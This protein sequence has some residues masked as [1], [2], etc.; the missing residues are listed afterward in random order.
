MKNKISTMKCLKY[1]VN[2]KV[3]FMKI[4]DPKIV[5]FKCWSFC[6]INIDYQKKVFVSAHWDTI[7]MK[8]IIQKF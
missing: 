3:E 6:K 4:Y 1:Y 8:T 5:L 2:M 7:T